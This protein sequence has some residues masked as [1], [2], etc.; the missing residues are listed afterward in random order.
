MNI[1]EFL[2]TT[3]T[4]YYQ[5][6]SLSFEPTTIGII[7]RCGQYLQELSFGGRWMKVTQRISDSMA[8]QC[9]ALRRLDLSAVIIHGDIS[10]VLDKVAE[11]LEDFSLEDTSWVDPEAPK[12]ITPY[13]PR[14]TR[15]R[16]L[17]MR[18]QSTAVLNELHNVGGE[19]DTALRDMRN[20]SLIKLLERQIGLKELVMCPSPVLLND[21]FMA[22]LLNLRAL[23][24]LRISH[25]PNEG[26]AIE[27]LGQLEGL[28]K[29]ALQEVRSLTEESLQLILTGLRKLESLSL[30]KCQNV[31]GF[32]ALDH[33]HCLEEL[34][35]SDNTNLVDDDL[36]SVF[37]L[38]GLKRLRVVRCS[39]VSTEVIVHALQRNQLE[40]LDLTGSTMMNDE[41]LFAI[42]STQNE[43]G[44]LSVNGCYKTSSKGV[45]AI[46]HMANIEKLDV[47]DVS[48]NRKI[49]EM[50]ILGLHNALTLKRQNRRF[51]RQAHQ[52]DDGFKAADLAAI[53]VPSKLLKVYATQSSISTNVDEAVADCIEIL[54]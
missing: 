21:E 31:Y 3:N 44:Y 8:S 7:D 53:E 22:R 13:F 36:F 10:D 6:D 32:S 9:H 47:L 11:N 35:I 46:S 42:A 34:E 48:N 2:K 27:L 41:A 15:L 16:R 40:T 30:A 17:N 39:N 5:Q 1:A 26:Y 28:R 12:K 25:V 50:A 54:R 49:N 33:C 19:L 51:E 45:A 37:G 4:E 29:L 20:S 38:G 18:A 24:T 23:H 43:L 52:E 14:M